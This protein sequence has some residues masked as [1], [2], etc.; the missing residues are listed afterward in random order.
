MLRW[1]WFGILPQKLLKSFYKKLSLD[2]SR[3]SW[4]QNIPT[5]SVQNNFL[6][7]SSQFPTRLLTE[8]HRWRTLQKIS[9]YRAK[10]L[11]SIRHL[12]SHLPRVPR[13]SPNLL[14]SSPGHH[15]VLVLFLARDYLGN[16]SLTYL[17]VFLMKLCQ[18][19]S[20]I[21]NSHHNCCVIC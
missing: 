14:M 11:P 5:N 16:N 17:I 8:T 3:H 15:V 2:R 13:Q 20:C 12:Q 9:S 19:L 7:E 21:Q 10:N 1:E 6:G 4:S 18:A